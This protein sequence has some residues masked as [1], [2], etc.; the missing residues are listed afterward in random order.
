M[1]DV[2]QEMGSGTCHLPRLKPLCSDSV[3]QVVREPVIKGRVSWRTPHPACP[4]KMG[5]VLEL[6][7]APVSLIPFSERA[8]FPRQRLPPSSIP[9]FSLK[10]KL[11]VPM[12][13]CAS[14]C[15]E[16]RAQTS[17]NWFCPYHFDVGSRDRTHI[18]RLVQQAPLPTEPPHQSTL[19]FRFV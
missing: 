6:L 3:G 1:V 7:L 5:I 17:G 10:K 4:R 13:T 15:V 9:S 8:L 11:C 18:T 16:G 2:F 14:S 19:A 12:C